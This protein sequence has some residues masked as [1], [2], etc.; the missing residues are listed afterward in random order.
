MDV[1]LYGQNETPGIVGV[2][3]LDEQHLRLYT[4]ESGKISHADVEFFPFFFLSTASLIDGFPK[5]FWLKELTGTNFYRT[6]VAFTRWNDM[7][8]AVRFILARY[9]K[10]SLRRVS[11]Y[12][13]S[14]ILLLRPDPVTQFLMQSG[15]TMFKGMTIAELRRL[16]ISIQALGKGGKPG[17]PGK[18]E[19]RIIAIGLSD[20]TGWEKVLHGRKDSEAE[21]L[22]EL[23]RLIHERDPDVLEGHSLFQHILPYLLKR[24]ELHGI[25][26]T[27]G[28]DGSVIRTSTPRGTPVDRE[29]ENAFFEV[30]GRH[31]VDTSTLAQTYDFSKR[32]LEGFS[33]H[34]LSAHFGV[35]NQQR[36]LVPPEKVASIWTEDPGR[37]CDFSLQEARETRAISDRLSP[38]YF[39]MTQ[40]C[41]LSYGTICRTGSAIKIE[42]LLLREYIRQKHSVPK[43]QGGTQTSGGYTDV[44]QTGLL[45]NVLHAD[46]ESLYP[47]V[48]LS[49][50]IKPSSDS[51][52]IFQVLLRDLTTKRLD[53]KRAMQ[54]A[55][56]ESTR[57]SYD[58]LQSSLKILINS[59]YGY[60]G[61]ARGLFNDYERA[62]EVTTSGQEYIRTILR[63]VELYNGRVIEVDTDGLFFIPPDNVR[64]PEQEEIF[65][66]K[67]G[68]SLP[69]GINLVLA[70]RYK[71]M[72][73]YKKKNYALLD[74]NDRL[75]IKGSALI[76]RSLE[77]FAKSYLHLCINRILQEDIEALHNLYSSFRKDIIGHNWAVLDFARTE[78]LHDSLERYTLEIQEEKRKPSA[79][80]EVARRAGLAFRS[81]DRISYY[82]TGG[83]AGVKIIDNCKLAEEWDPNFP[84]ENTAYYLDRLDEASAKFE[85]FFEPE[86][87]KRIFS[88]ED[89]FGFSP[90]GITIINKFEGSVDQPSKEERESSQF[91]IWLDDEQEPG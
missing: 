43:P 69:E 90:E 80:Y 5:R 13:E 60:L 42:S 41:P 68:A 20:S 4:R 19:D 86:D 70:G 36:I 8:E 17:N 64:G 66:Q 21:M 2:Q 88:A 34:H 30:P 51:L 61:Y 77:R 87:W 25:E 62:D 82:V 48:M 85:V 6:L 12:T 22:T 50:A 16:Q 37:V 81:G 44:F 55:K 75:S 59:F 47:S 76:S 58:A 63:Q 3:Q 33:L 72:L 32:T 7:W 79:A 28:R 65:V 84:D 89:L 46:I 31:L 74:F 54:Q 35:S 18:T 38:S 91:G 45:Q 29:F 53:A 71:K 10:T 40:M 49:K 23:L 24:F 27:I 14:D 57:A 39:F 83:T 1:V 11:S 26:C 73:S 78:T 67:I 56:K 15:T 9:N 52:G